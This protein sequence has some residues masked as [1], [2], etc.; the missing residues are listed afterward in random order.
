MDDK[1]LVIIDKNDLDDLKESFKSIN[2]SIKIL[3]EEISEL[4]DMV[5]EKMEEDV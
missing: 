4:N 5:G 1:V 2:E 3:A